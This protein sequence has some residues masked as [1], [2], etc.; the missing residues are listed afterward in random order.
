[1]PEG[2]LVSR[3]SMKD[4]HVQM[5]LTVQIYTQ[6][7]KWCVTSKMEV[8]RLVKV[9]QTSHLKGY[10]RFSHSDPF[11]SDQKKTENVSLFVRNKEI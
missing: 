4:V 7:E 5:E 1:M 6:P 2:V 9:S 8:L 3:C 10:S 11:L